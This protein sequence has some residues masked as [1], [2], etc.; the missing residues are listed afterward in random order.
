MTVEHSW[1][2]AVV[3]AVGIV[4]D[5]AAVRVGRPFVVRSGDILSQSDRLKTQ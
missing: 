5:A 1:F 2:V 3:V 4:A